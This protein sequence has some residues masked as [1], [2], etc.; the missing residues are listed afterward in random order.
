MMEIVERLATLAL[1]QTVF[2]KR[3]L[4]IQNL[5]SV[6]RESLW[7]IGAVLFCYWLIKK[8]DWLYIDLHH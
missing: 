4:C 2:E 3:N 5:K 1:S 8:C 7:H 6:V